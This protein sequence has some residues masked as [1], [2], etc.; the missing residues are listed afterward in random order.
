[1]ASFVRHVFRV[2]CSAPAVEIGG[3]YKQQDNGLSAVYTGPDGRQLTLAGVFD[4]HGSRRGEVYSQLCV[5]TVKKHVSGPEFV[6]A[7]YANPESVGREIFAAIRTD[8]F[9]A[10]QA[11]LDRLGL[12]YTVSG[13]GEDQHIQTEHMDKIAGGSTG[14]L[15]FV[16]DTGEI[17]TFNVGDSD[18]WFVSGD[19]A[20]ALCTDHS[21][22]SEREFTRIHATWPDTKFEYD[23]QV[24]CGCLRHPGGSHVFPRRVGFNGYYRKNVSG[25]MAAVMIVRGYRLAMTR[26]FGDE[27][28]RCG[29]LSAEP[30]YKCVQAD[31]SGIIRVASDGFWDNIQNSEMIA[32]TESA[33]ASHGFDAHALNSEWLVHTHEKAKANFGG[34]R[35]NMFAYTICIEKIE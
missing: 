25:D 8:C 17:H 20:Q 9:A 10:N 28:F 16:T 5:D 24:A 12:A 14:T 27:R 11:E 1:M 7:F 19:S 23:Y 18:A 35:D 31:A 33:V 32:E 2:T 21:P 34:G 15:V 3:Q 6:P 22:S 29:G 26:S 30:G 4:G 13:E